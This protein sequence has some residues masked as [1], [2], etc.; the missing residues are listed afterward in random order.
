MKEIAALTILL[1]AVA[2]AQSPEPPASQYS[3]LAIQYVGIIDKP[4]FPI[5]IRDSKTGAEWY[6]TAV[7]KRSDRQLTYAHVVDASL[8]ANLIREAESYRDA[9]QK[10]GEPKSSDGKA[11][12]LTLVTAG[13][14]R[15]FQLNMPSAVTLLETSRINPV[16]T[17]H[18]TPISSTFRTESM[19]WLSV[20]S[21]LL[22]ASKQA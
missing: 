6:R 4:V 13:N 11:V 5:I 14:R 12:S 8:V 22:K 20:R 15:A 3:V 17:H 9:A 19:P 10:R 1:L 18:C 16:A 2:P 7:L 21:T